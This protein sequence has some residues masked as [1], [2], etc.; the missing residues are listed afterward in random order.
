MG[1]KQARSV[2]GYLAMSMRRGKDGSEYTGKRER[3][4]GWKGRRTLFEREV[5]SPREDP[6]LLLVQ[7]FTEEKES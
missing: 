6:R 2:S 4:K 5:P 3:K 7:T 1:A